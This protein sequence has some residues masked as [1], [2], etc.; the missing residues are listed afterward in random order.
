MWTYRQPASTSWRRSRAGRR[1][2]RR[3]T[4]RRRRR[5]RGAP[6]R[7]ALR[8]RSGPISVTL[9]GVSV[10][11][12]AKVNSSSGWLRAGA[13]GRSPAC[14]G[15]ARTGSA[16]RSGPAVRAARGQAAGRP[17]AEPGVDARDVGEALHEARP[18]ELAVDDDREAVRSCSAMRPRIASSCSARAVLGQAAVGELTNARERRRAQHPSHVVHSQSLQR[19]EPPPP[20][21][22]VTSILWRIEEHVAQ[23]GILEAIRSKG[24]LVTWREHVG[25]E[26]ESS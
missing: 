6:G 19:H 15:G 14:A 16:P 9:T 26:C 7:R 11:L 25:V 22:S 4:R 13:A 5:R 21:Q 17:A 3:G 20:L 8:M 23:D 10:P 18:A 2:R 24:V 12:A 1:R